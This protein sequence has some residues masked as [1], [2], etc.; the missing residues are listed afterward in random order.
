M[1]VS[2]FMELSLL[3]FHQMDL[4]FHTG[5]ELRVLHAV[6]QVGIPVLMEFNHIITLGQLTQLDQRLFLKK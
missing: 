5:R 6:D 3:L 1:E 2:G 4:L